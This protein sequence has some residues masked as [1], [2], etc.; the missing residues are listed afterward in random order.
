M[1]QYI[2]LLATDVNQNLHKKCKAAWE[3][4]GVQVPLYGTKEQPLPLFVSS[5][6][7]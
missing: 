1:L 3:V 5:D 4:E 6:A 2:H 7:I